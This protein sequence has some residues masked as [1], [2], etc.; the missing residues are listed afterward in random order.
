MHGADWRRYFK[1]VGDEFQANGIDYI[2]IN[3]EKSGE[4]EK[5]SITMEIS[6][7]PATWVGYT[8]VYGTRL[9]AANKVL[10]NF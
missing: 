10:D 7:Y 2:E 1:K 4:K 8:Q 3:V 5:M 6:S 9:K